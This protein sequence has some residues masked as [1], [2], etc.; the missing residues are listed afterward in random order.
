MDPALESE[1]CLKGRPGTCPSDSSESS[2]EVYPVLSE[3][4][5]YS[6][7]TVNSD[8]AGRKLEV[9]S[10]MKAQCRQGLRNRDV[11][12]CV[13]KTKKETMTTKNIFDAGCLS[14]VISMMLE[15]EEWREEKEE[16]KRNKVTKNENKKEN[17]NHS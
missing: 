16:E 1:P 7:S 9:N 15:E 13:T 12:A 11:V 2:S 17:Q 6:T 8:E 4:L 3:S 5:M 10:L 14:D